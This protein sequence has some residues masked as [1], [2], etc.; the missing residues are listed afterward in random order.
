MKPSFFALFKRGRYFRL[1]PPSEDD[2]PEVLRRRKEAERFT[3]AAV[4]FCMF[5]H[6][7]FARV[8]LHN[9]CNISVQPKTKVTVDVEPE[10]WADLLIGVGRSICVVEFKLGAPLQ[11]HQNPSEAVFWGKRSGYGA[12]LQ[13]AYPRAKKHFVILGHRGYIALPERSGWQF[14]QANWSLLADGFE[15][16]FGKSKLLCDLRDCLAQFEIWEFASM[17]ARELSVFSEDVIHGSLAWEILRQAYLCPDLD[18]SRSTKAY[19]LDAEVGNRSGWHFGIEIQNRASKPL[20]ELIRPT[21]NGPLMWFGYESPGRGKVDHS[22]WFYCETRLIAD[23]IAEGMR[24]S[25]QDSYRVLRPDDDE[26][27][28]SYVCI[29]ERSLIGR[30]DFDWF[31]DWLM[32]AKHLADR[33][34]QVRPPVRVK[35][36]LPSQSRHRSMR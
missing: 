16:R 6:P 26:D 14:A 23:L 3:A 22:I 36:R 9:I 27:D 33:S 24:H 15:A 31:G 29:R 30:H 17:K 7:N 13:A 21:T 25:R 8:F 28:S 19:L 5:H 4:G 35:R 18:F 10:S 32:R 11:A 2:D 1:P 12:K 20:R 34:A